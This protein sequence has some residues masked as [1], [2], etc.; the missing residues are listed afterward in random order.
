MRLR[1]LS[2]LAL[3]GCGI[4][5]PSPGEYGSN[6]P[7]PWPGVE[8][9]AIFPFDVGAG[10]RSAPDLREFEQIFATEV[11][12]FPGVRV[13]RP[14]DVAAAATGRKIETVN[15]AL[16]LARDL[17]ADA[18]LAV[19]V[20]DY[21]GYRNPKISLDVQ[22]VAAGG[23]A[24]GADVEALTMIGRWFFKGDRRDAGDVAAAF[25][26]VR[27]SHHRDTYKNMTKYRYAHETETTSF[28]ENT[29]GRFLE[30]QSGFLQFASNDLVRELWSRAP[31][32]EPEKPAAKP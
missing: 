30:T 4:I 12:K 24:R 2:L 8:T 18:V 16:G 27:E 5:P 26:M 1:T 19:R 25:E 11:A 6:P 3:A 10:L 31:K 13:I 7:N 15:D 20:T 29:P 23:R 17:K 28:K 14:G 9:I 21:D 22:L 32:P